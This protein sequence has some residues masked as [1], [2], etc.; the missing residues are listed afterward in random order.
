M[1]ARE[2]TLAREVLV[3]GNFITVRC[4]CLFSPLRGYRYYG[5]KG[6]FPGTPCNICNGI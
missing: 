3:V 2:E 1:I 4:T 5:P 6:P